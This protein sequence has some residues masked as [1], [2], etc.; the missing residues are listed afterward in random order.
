MSKR[1]HIQAGLT[2]SGYE[3]GYLTCHFHNL[4]TQDSVT[5]N[6]SEDDTIW[7]GIM[8]GYRM[9]DLALNRTPDDVV[10]EVYECF[11]N[12]DGQWQTNCE[13]SWVLTNAWV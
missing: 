2:L 7:E 9:F 4:L 10:C 6:L 12:A 11:K 8:V 3:R 5:E 1:T 13:K